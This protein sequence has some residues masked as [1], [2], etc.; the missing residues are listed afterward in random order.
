MQARTYR[1]TAVNLPLVLG[2]GLVVLALY[3]AGLLVLMERADYDVWGALLLGPLL[4]GATVPMLVRQAAREGDPALLRLLVFALLLKMGGAI[5]RHFVAFTVYQGAAD[6]QSYHQW[7]VALSQQFWRGDF[8]TGL[9]DLTGTNA[10]RFLTGVAYSFIGPTKLGGFLL[11]SWVGFL[12]LFLFYRAFTIAVPEGRSRSYARLVFFLPSLVFWPSSIGKEAWMTFAIGIAVYG[13]AICLGGWSVRGIAIL[14]AGLWLTGFVRPHIAGLLGV[15]FALAVIARPVAP[16][17][18]EL[19]P[20]LKLCSI[21]VVSVLALVLASRASAF[22]ESAGIDVGSGVEQTLEDVQ[23]RTQKGG[24]DFVPSIAD[25]P[26]RAPVAVVTVLFRPFLFEAHNA[27]ALVSALETTFLLLLSLLRLPWV[28]AAVRSMRRQ[29]YVVF[30]AAYVTLGIVAFSSFANF[31]LL[32]RERVQLYPLFLVLLFILPPG[33][34][35]SPVAAVEVAG[36]A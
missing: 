21:V 29:P 22:L 30:C 10:V 31:G 36:T 18:R 32:A 27:Q 15:A 9:A 26:S 2:S 14:A 28:L 13:I 12:G 17:S 5:A 3:V 16:G 24:S 1:P 11:F 33:R 7:G 4:V 35:P 23:A 19:A 6:A 8:D 25:S 34:A 20:L